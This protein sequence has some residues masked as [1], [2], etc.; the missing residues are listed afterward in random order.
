MRAKGVRRMVL[1]TEGRPLEIELDTNPFASIPDDAIDSIIDEAR[2]E[3]DDALCAM[4]QKQ[5]K[6]FALN[7]Q[8]C[9]ACG[10]KVGGVQGLSDG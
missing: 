1:D 5:P 4:C 6:G 2:R 3:R 10:L 7:P 8:L 9:R